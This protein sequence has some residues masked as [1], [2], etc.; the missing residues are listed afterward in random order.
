MAIVRLASPQEAHRA[1]GRLNR[2]FV[3]ERC[4]TMRVLP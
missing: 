3:Q 4:I 1:F 2:N